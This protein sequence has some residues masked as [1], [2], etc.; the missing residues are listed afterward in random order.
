MIAVGT[1][2]SHNFVRNLFSSLSTDGDLIGSALT[3]ENDKGDT[4]LHYAAKIGNMIDAK[5][6]VSYSSKPAEMALHRNKNG[7]TPLFYAASRG[8]KKELLHYLYSLTGVFSSPLK[9]GVPTP[10]LLFGVGPLLTN[11]IDAGFLAKGIKNIHDLKR[12]HKQ[13]KKLVKHICVIVKEKGY[14]DIICA[15][16]GSTITTAVESGNYEVLKECISAYPS[17]IWS[18]FEEFKLLH[19]AIKQRQEQVYNLIYQMSTYKALVLSEADDETNENILHIAA[20]LAPSHRLNNITG[21]A[22][23]MQR[24]LQWFEEIESFVEPSLK[25]DLNKDKQT[26]RM[27]FKEQ[28]KE[29][30]QQGKEWMKDTASSSTVVAALVVTVAFAAVFTLPGGEANKGK[31]AFT[32][33]ILSDATALFSSA[34]STLLFLGI[35]TSRYAEED[36]LH[37]LP[38]RLMG[39][40]FS[41]FLSLAAT[42]ITFSATLAL[43]L[44]DEGTW[45]AAPLV[46][47]TSEGGKIEGA[48]TSRSRVKEGGSKEL[49]LHVSG[50]G[51]RIEGAATS[52]SRY[53]NDGDIRLEIGMDYKRWLKAF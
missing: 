31:L 52:R 2:R 46:I 48:A 32:L 26:P 53:G 42:M 20:K 16:L 28:H 14:Q 17:V 34:T 41:L 49:Q 47:I 4:A 33:F 39:G 1:N 6:L 9:S 21:A 15:I 22:L 50:E 45:I 29:L 13:T 24:E 19:E 25:G 11:A 35:L 36:F 40:L 30:L 18:E 10:S 23:Q 37:V 3:A 38:R 43:V 12:T 51:R 27:V 7:S 5:L 44:Q 8:R